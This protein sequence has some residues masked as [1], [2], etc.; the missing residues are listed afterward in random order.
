M[1]IRSIP[2]IG[3]PAGRRRST[4]AAI[5]TVRLLAFDELWTSEVEG[6]ERGTAR[7]EE[8]YAALEQLVGD[9]RVGLT[10]LRDYAYELRMMFSEQL[11]DDA[12]AQALDAIAKLPTVPSDLLSILSSAVPDYEV[13]GAVI[14]ACDYVRETAAAESDLLDA[15][16]AAILRGETSPGDFRLP[17]TCAALLLLV[18]AGVAGSIGLGGAPLYVSLTIGSQVGLGALGWVQGKCPKVL[19]E[20]T[21]GR[22]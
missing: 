17:F 3:T 1:A 18:G 14:A 9:M 22:R 7:S 8:D 21:F 2:N 5:L 20:I 16:L 15:K 4:E 6:T 13:R 10:E 11:S 19:P 12:V